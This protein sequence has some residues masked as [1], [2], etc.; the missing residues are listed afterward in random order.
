MFELPPDLPPAYPLEY[1]VEQK[2][3]NFNSEHF[4]IPP[5]ALEA[6]RR[7]EN[8]KVCAVSKNTNDTADLGPMQINTIHLPSIKEQYPDIDFTDVACKP[9]LNITI[10]SWILS[11]RLKEV[12]GDVW[13]AVG[14]YHSKTPHVRLRYLSKIEKAVNEIKKEKTAEGER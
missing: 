2:C 10:G 3:I 6:I 1:A 5:I 7:V 8:G 12:E 14:N 9:C 4:G 13:L 11:Q